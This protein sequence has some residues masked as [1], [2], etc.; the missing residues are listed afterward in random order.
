MKPILP[1]LVLLLCAGGCGGSSPRPARPPAAAFSVTVGSLTLSHRPERIVSLTPSVTEVLFAIGAGP[2]VVA[3]DEDSNFPP[4]APKTGLSGFQPDPSAIAAQRPDL[5]VLA[6]DS[7]GVRAGLQKRGIPVFLA[8]DPGS[9]DDAYRAI[10]QLGVLTGHAAEAEALHQR[11]AAGIARIVATVPRRA[12]PLTYYYELDPTYYTVTSRTFVGSI[13][14]M[15][16][17]TNVADAA[18]PRGLDG[19]YPKLAA[20]TVVRMNPGAV[21]LADVGCCAQSSRTI[22]AR[23][24]WSTVSA[25]RANR[26]FALDDDIAARWGPRTVD[27]VQSIANAVAVIPR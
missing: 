6:A 13:F 4:A 2:Q 22:A 14:A 5:V 1:V 12:T 11:M 18:D 21:F 25:V 23:P 19:G 16:G 26:V 20:A 24:G 8:P 17:L 7:N 15:F 3:A 9:V 10:G 27:L